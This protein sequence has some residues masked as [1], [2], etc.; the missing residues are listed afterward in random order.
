MKKDTSHIKVD[1]QHKII[2]I[3]FEGDVGDEN[4]K[5]I[6][7]D[8]LYHADVKKINIFFIDQ[9]KLGKVS[10]SSRSW[11]LLE[12]VQLIK[13]KLKNKVQV[14]I[15]PSNEN[16]HSVSLKFMIKS[17]SI[18]TKFKTTLVTSKKEIYDFKK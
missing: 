12:M 4:Y 17:V 8:A 10:F 3:Y 6:W 1:L 5:K 18:I 11:F 13:Q 7:Y 9:S 16:S 14:F 2:E 15:K